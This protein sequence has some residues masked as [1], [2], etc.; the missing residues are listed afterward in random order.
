[1]V[2]SN[3]YPKI[4]VDSHVT[5]VLT[6]LPRLLWNVAALWTIKPPHVGH[7]LRTPLGSEVLRR[8]D[9]SKAPGVYVFL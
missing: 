2:M 8:V 7:R 6:G 9:W 5:P 4:I 1:M 3:L